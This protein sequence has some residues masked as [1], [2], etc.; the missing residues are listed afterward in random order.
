MRRSQLSRRQLLGGFLTGLFG[1]LGAAEGRPAAAAPAPALR[2]APDGPLPVTTYVA[3]AGG[4]WFAVAQDPPAGA[5]ADA[6][7]AFRYEGGPPP[8]APA[9]TTCTAYECR[10][11]A[12]PAGR[13]T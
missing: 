3:G 5:A 13:G 9:A 8:A 12:A 7:A 1:S 6:V 11:L 10:D 2:P 4:R